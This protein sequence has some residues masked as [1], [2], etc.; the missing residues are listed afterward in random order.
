MPR[1][2]E[3]CVLAAHLTDCSRQYVLARAEQIQ[4]EHYFFN[5][6]LLYEPHITL[7]R[8]LGEQHIPYCRQYLPNQ[9]FHMRVTG[10]SIRC[11]PGRGRRP[12]ASSPQ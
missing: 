9:I 12:R 8:G 7:L 3:S 4:S 5:I 10:T 6:A 11:A 1:K 2:Y